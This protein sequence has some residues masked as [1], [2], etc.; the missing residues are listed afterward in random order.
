MAKL[1][2]VLCVIMR[3]YGQKKKMENKL[4]KM[5]ILIVENDA[6]LHNFYIHTLKAFTDQITV[7]H[8]GADAIRAL[9]EGR[10]RLIFLN[11]RLPIVDGEGVLAYIR[12]TP[13]LHNTHVV[14]ISSVPYCQRHIES[15][16]SAEFLLKPIMPSDIRRIALRVMKQ[17]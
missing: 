1:F 13:C 16:P 3:S 17:S 4:L 7:T 2:K 15:L 12:S 9:Q 14:L 10:P 6:A 11:M 8:N 5:E